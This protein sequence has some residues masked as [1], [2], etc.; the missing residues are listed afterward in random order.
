MNY[1]K[2]IHI[3]QE[4]S[5]QE[6]GQYLTNQV[7]PEAI[8][9]DEFQPRALLFVKILSVFNL[10]AQGDF[11]AL[12]LLFSTINFVLCWWTFSVLIQIYPHLKKLFYVCLFL[13]P[14]FVF[15][16]SGLMEESLI[17]GIMFC[18]QAI[19]LAIVYQ[20]LKKPIWL[21][22]IFLLI[23]FVLVWKIKYYFVGAFMGFFVPYLLVKMYC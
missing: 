7:I 21:Y 4:L 10:I 1:L 8:I 9:Y 12:S 3:L 5:W 17:V 16:T 13:N 14:S 20:K 6:Y 18:C 23:S 19:F 22:I 15:W 2:D 11:W